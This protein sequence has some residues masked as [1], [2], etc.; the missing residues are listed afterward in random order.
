VLLGEEV[1]GVNGELVVGPPAIGELEE[2]VAVLVPDDGE[3]VGLLEFVEREIT[4]LSCH[5]TIL[6]PTVSHVNS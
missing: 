4:S 5:G 6:S 2:L 3:G 1:G